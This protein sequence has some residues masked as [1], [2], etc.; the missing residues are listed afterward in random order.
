MALL[1]RVEAA[2]ALGI[3]V[4]LLEAFVAECAKPNGN[5]RLQ[6]TSAG[7]LQFFSEDELHD[8]IEHL[9]APW[10]LPPA[11]GRP[12]IPEA[13]TR[14]VRQ[15]SNQVC[16]ICGRMDNV[17]IAHIEAVASTI[18]NSPGNLVLLCPNH[19]AKYDHG[20]KPASDVTGELTRAAKA[21]KRRSRARVMR[22]GADV[23]KALRAT[24]RLL[25]TIEEGLEQAEASSV[26]G[27]VLVTEAR[28]LLESVPRL[29]SSISASPRKDAD[30]DVFRLLT[31]EAPELMRLASVDFRTATDAVVRSA[32]VGVVNAA[33]GV[34]IDLDEVDCPHCGGTGTRGLVGDFCS[35]CRGAQVVTESQ[36]TIYEFDAIDEVPCPHC[37]GRGL[38]GVGGHLCAYCRGSQVMPRARADAYIKDAMDEVE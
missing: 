13:L 29:V 30:A 38:F 26:K 37:G 5:R 14:D 15:E 35:Y 6:A 7:G 31:K 18:N 27:E 19:H 20:Y 24:I 2:I 25:G 33:S 22:C 21:V 34:L 17:E 3:S 11:G 1:T 4:E 12:A 23:T 32:V 28:S 10:P 8:F 9:N 36:A 16:A